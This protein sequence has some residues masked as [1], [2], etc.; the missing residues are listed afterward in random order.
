[1]PET[2]P[3]NG[4]LSIIDDDGNA[5][6]ISYLLPLMQSKNLPIGL[7][8]AGKLIVDGALDGRPSMT[9]SQLR[10]LKN[11]PLVEIMNH[12]YS[13]VGLA[14]TDKFAVYSELKK[15]HDWLYERGFIAE[16][17]VSPYGAY[18]LTSI[19]EANKLY[20][21]HYSTYPDTN[22]IINMKN[23]EIGRLNFGSDGVGLQ[24]LKNAI[25]RAKANNEYLVIMTHVGGY[26][27]YANWRPDFENLVDYIV[28]SG[29]TVL[30]P[31]DA[32]NRYKNMF[33]RYGDYKIGADGMKRKY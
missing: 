26:N 17:Y 11:N 12:T 15:N 18:S 5:D 9:D 30:K 16:S 23:L 14:G 1:M 20:E 4:I 29:I 24:A 28:A 31:T 32:F 25:D 3:T 13:H 33:E 27:N 8:I 22:T 2:Y 6:V 10:G 21:S 19:S 7:A